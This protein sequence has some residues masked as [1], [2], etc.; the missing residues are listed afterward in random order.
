MLIKCPECGKEVSSEAKTCIHCGYPIA[1]FIAQ[2]EEELRKQKVEAEDRNMPKRQ[3]KVYNV[4]CVIQYISIIVL[5]ITLLIFGI[6]GL[7]SNGEPFEGDVAYVSV[8]LLI[9]IIGIIIDIIVC[10]IFRACF[11]RR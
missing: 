4:F 1:K 7:A 5:L 6:V 3:P 2:K 9:E 8:F 11:R 10:G